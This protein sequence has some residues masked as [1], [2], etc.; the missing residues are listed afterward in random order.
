[1]AHGSGNADHET[2]DENA[3]VKVPPDDPNFTLK[4]VWLSVRKRFRLK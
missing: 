1:V 4:R 2:V 3:R